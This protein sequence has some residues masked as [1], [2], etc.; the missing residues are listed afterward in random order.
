MAT[1]SVQ[2]PGVP[3]GNKFRVKLQFVIGALDATSSQFRV[4]QDVEWSAW[5][6]LKGIINSKVRTRR[7]LVFNRGSLCL[8]VC[9][10]VADSFGEAA[11]KMGRVGCF[12]GGRAGF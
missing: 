11:Q 9:V 1:S 2:T 7:C 4:S 6:M 10:C 3:Q 12:G 5:S 8:S